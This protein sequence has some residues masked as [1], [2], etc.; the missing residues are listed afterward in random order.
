M[1]PIHPIVPH[2]PTI[3][4]IGG[5]PR[6]APLTREGQRQPERQPQR[7][8]ERDAWDQEDEDDDETE[9]QSSWDG[10]ERRSTPRDQPDDDDDGPRLHIDISV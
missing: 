9:L 2:G 10:T 4:P 3:P 1:D 7:Q 5:S 8:D 6:I